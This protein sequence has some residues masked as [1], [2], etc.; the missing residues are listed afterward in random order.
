MPRSV[1]LGIAV[2]LALGWSPPSRAAE[3]D[4][5]ATGGSQGLEEITVTAQ[6]RSENLQKVPISI[7]AI[8]GESLSQGGVVNVTGISSRVPSMATTMPYGDAIP[9]FSL[10][11]ISAVDYSQNQASPVALYV[12]EVYKGLPVFTSLQL[13]DVDSVEVLRGPQGTLY[14][15]NTT[16]G[17]VNIHTVKPDV[18][19]GLDG[20]VNVGL[21]SLNRKDFAA[22]LN[23]PVSDT[24]ATR[25]AV[26]TSNVDGM[27]EN[28]QPGVEDQ[29]EI[30]DWA[31]RIGAVWAPT[32]DLE[33][34]LRLTASEST[35][36][37]YGVIADN[38]GRSGSG[39]A[40]FFSG[41]TR[42][43]LSFWENETDIPGK[44]RIR[45]QS[46][47]A[48]ITWDVSNSLEVTSITSYDRGYWLTWEDADGSPYRIVASK[49]VNDAW[50]WSE[51]LRIASQGDSSF[52]WIGGLYVYQDS[53]SADTQYQYFHE[54]AALD[55]SGMPI[56]F[57]DFITGC[58][59]SNR[60]RQDRESYAAYA[61]GTYEATS[62][63][64]FT[65]GLRYTD[66]RNDLPSYKAWLG[67]LDPTTG[68]DVTNAVQTIDGAPTDQLKSTNW[69]G[70]IGAQYQL[71]ERTLLYASLTRGYRGGSFNGQAFYDPSE[72]TAA[73]PEKVDSYEIGAK[74]EIADN[75]VRLN[76]ALFYYDYVNQQF[77]A[78]TPEFLQIL[79]NAPKSRLYGA[80][81]ELTAQPVPAF[82][83]HLGASYL[84]SEYQ[85]AVLQGQDISGNKLILAPEWTAN[86]GID[87]T[88]LDSAWGS[89][90]LHT[91][92]RYMSKVY[93]DAFNTNAVA[94]G[95]YAVHDARLSATLTSHPIQLT[96]WVRNLTNE[97]Y[98]VYRLN[99]AA[100]TNYDY[101]QRGRPREYGVEVR[102]SF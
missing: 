69:S 89:L 1:T 60:F 19:A 25:V 10:R 78:V 33:V 95:G 55:E 61:E 11:G 68:T 34:T 80:E 38:I 4:E 56:C 82:E 35:P 14:G 52:Q 28:R 5:T 88:L 83:F 101:G 75:R 16:G 47:A 22:A 74:T 18:A 84:N 26:Q 86:G 15:K 44:L 50:A 45:N 30:R 62:R 67:Y 65:L 41:Y 64:S 71:D 49:Y 97:E 91:D 36:S 24:F 81:V 100:L 42:Q 13:F 51:D 7:S 53:I 39:G 37:G 58:T 72:V 93:Y 31:G 87:W 76:G 85:E 92:S 54:L 79:Y 40:G 3:A 46:V 29:G 21:G 9:I 12:D 70:R 8:S 63:L 43:G 6:R 77:L 20:Y 90:T 98:R 66:D 94:Q 57:A 17:A 48:K 32:D 23:I 27:V 102:Y 73:K 96:T 2:A 59:V 99:V